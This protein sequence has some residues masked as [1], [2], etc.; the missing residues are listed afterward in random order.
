MG[1]VSSS[2][3]EAL[4]VWEATAGLGQRWDGV[5]PAKDEAP[6]AQASIDGDDALRMLQ[7]AQTQAVLAVSQVLS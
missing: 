3:G 7:V 5:A 6:S 2:A 4:G 1:A